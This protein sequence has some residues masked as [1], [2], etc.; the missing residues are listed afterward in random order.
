MRG[1]EDIGGAS[2]ATMRRLFLQFVTHVAAQYC[3]EFGCR[4]ENL[5]N[6]EV[7]P[8]YNPN[9]SEEENIY[10]RFESLNHA[11]HTHLHV[12][13]HFSFAMLCFLHSPPVCNVC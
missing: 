4:K 13:P 2:S 8:N 9:A 12:C 5:S 7:N 1:E 11:L 6:R 3:C 10:Y